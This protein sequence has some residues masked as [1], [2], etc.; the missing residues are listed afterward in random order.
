MARL[1][2]C[3]A[4]AGPSAS[5][6]ASAVVSRA[7]FGVRHDKGNQAP[8]QRLCG[9]D[10]VAEHHQ[11]F[12]QYR[13]DQPCYPQR[14]AA[15]GICADLDFGQSKPGAF[16]CN[17]YV[18]THGDFETT[19][20]RKT[21]HRRNRRLPAPRKAIEQNVDWPQ[22][23]PASFRQS[24][25]S[26]QSSFRSKPGAKRPLTVAPDNDGAHAHVTFEF[27]DASRE[28]GAHLHIDR[29]HRRRRNDR[30]RNPILNVDCNFAHSTR[31]ADCGS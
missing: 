1:R 5:R 18:T 17:N 4:S 24:P 21:G 7:Q 16:A 8:L 3:K 14:A 19:A 26:S 28:F 23:Y 9:I 25:T 15:G 10:R 27:F 20:K 31:T 29:V 6:R 2:Y 11:T 30:R 13:S 12:G 22:D